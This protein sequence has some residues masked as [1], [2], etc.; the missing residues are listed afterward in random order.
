MW[1]LAKSKNIRIKCTIPD[2]EYPI[3]ADRSLF[4]RVLTNLLSNAIKYSPRD[5]TITCALAYEQQLAGANIVCSI[6]DQGYG[7]PR[8]AKQTISTLSTLRRCRPQK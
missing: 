5:T 6:S 3:R 2:G 8:R 4:T 7:I 1:S